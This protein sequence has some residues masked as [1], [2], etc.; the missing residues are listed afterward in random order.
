MD[1]KKEPNELYSLN[2]DGEQKA[3]SEKEEKENEKNNN[4][5][6]RIETAETEMILYPV[7]PKARSQADDH[8]DVTISPAFQTLDQLFAN[9]QITGEKAARLKAK[10]QDLLEFL[11][12]TR[13]SESSLLYDAKSLIQEAQRQRLEL[14]K[15]EA[16]PD[17]EDN[18][19]KRLRSQWLKHNN[20]LSAA[21][22]RMY[23]LEF[24]VEN[25]KE[26]RRLLEREYS[27][28][29]KTDELDKQL[30]DLNTNIDD[31]RIEIAQRSH[32]K[33]NLKDELSVR[34]H[35][36][37]VLLK[38]IEKKDVDQQDLKD[39]LLKIH[40]EPA[41]LSKQSDLIM[42]HQRDYVEK[43]DH[44]TQ[45][46]NDFNSEIKKVGEKKSM[47][48]T[49]KDQ[50]SKALDEQRNIYEEKERE[51]DLLVKEC[52]FAK[53]QQAELLGDRT[54]LDL[55]LKHSLLDKKNEHDI[56]ARKQREKDRNLKTLKKADLQLKI[57]LDGLAH[58][59]SIYDKT[60]SQVDSL[61]KD[62]GSLFDKRKELQREVDIVRHNL[63]KQNGLTAYER[64]CVD[65]GIHEEEQLLAEQGQLRIDVVDLTRLAQIKADEREQKARDY[66]KADLRYQKALE[67]LRT[68]ELTIQDSAKK[69]IEV[70]HRLQDF[71]KR[72]D[73]IKN[74]RNKCVNLIQTSTQRAAEM[75]EKIKILQN[76]IEILRTA[77]AARERHLQKAKLKHAS[78]VVIRDS[79]RNEVSK[80]QLTAEELKEKRE[81]QR[82]AIAK[83]N[84]MISKAEEN[85]V[86]LRRQYESAV[87]ERNSRG[88]QLIE[89]NEEVCVFYEKVNVQ[90]SMIRNGD[91]E[92]KN[93]EEEIRFMKMESADLRRSNNLMNRTVPQK[94]S[95]DDELVTLQLQLLECQEYLL[96]LEKSL[97]NPS[98]SDR[99]RLLGGK[100][101]S[102]EELQQKIEQLEKR[103]AEKEEKMLEKELIH[104]E[105]T[106]LLD[107][108][109]K[110][111]ETGKDDTL[112]LAKKVNEI[113]AKIKDM[114]RKMM[115]MVSELSMNQAKAL[116]LQQEL[117]D[118]EAYLEQCYLRL[119]R[120]EP[121]SDEIEMEWQKQVRQ[122]WLRV[123]EARQRQTADEE[124]EL[125]TISGGITTTAE[126]RPNAYI[127]DDES[128]LPVPR[129]YGAHA[130]FKPAQP[131]SN[132]RHIRKPI[133]KPI[134]L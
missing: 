38:N 127:P 25:L 21:D 49:E 45:Q 14:E 61:P 57:A 110:K 62:D 65:Q 88:I 54:S 120:G 69:Y 9:G 6:R 74:E 133:I 102:Q 29:P 46:I 20:E 67:D 116:R 33:S 30:K 64:Q 107:R 95:L 24:K 58:I 72:Y 78:A 124:L 104:E 22:E 109:K 111:A 97:E 84:D 91:M 75:K 51:V 121:P 37:E 130:P 108:T 96:D 1:D 103:L 2:E 7:A 86:E 81:Q 83:L 63:A 56:H 70:Q 47:Y 44:L 50:L 82:L 59:K 48:L 92:M 35:Q 122:E 43:R 16:F 55:N 132:M 73:I 71:A 3:V 115:A 23:Q 68:K 28:R 118:K 8:V 66:L 105:V 87:H 42:R 60:K 128:E 26:E 117:K 31:L 89:R 85:M 99:V 15:G 123:K 10:Y 119:E 11:K 32:E 106:R 18:E 101:P 113:Q 13:E 126:P 80:Q 79:L 76:E 93:R 98:K 112:K 77:A 129:P 52:D 12:T 53:E 41:H 40:S 125:Y 90:D 94:R 34:E 19:V 36:I 5:Q 27:R 100:D 4:V 114:T 131:G 17:I 39:Q 134:E